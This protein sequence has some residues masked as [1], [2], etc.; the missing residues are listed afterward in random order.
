M[1][2]QVERER[3]R[4]REKER[5]RLMRKMRKSV[6]KELADFHFIHFTVGK[7]HIAV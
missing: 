5:E 6:I 2:V 3:E 1:N 7:E 4:D